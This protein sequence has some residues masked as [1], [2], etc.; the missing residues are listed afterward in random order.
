MSNTLR[1]EKA[2]AQW[3][4]SGNGGFSQ[5][6]HGDKPL[7]QRNYQRVSANPVVF[8]GKTTIFRPCGASC[9]PNSISAAMARRVRSFIESFTSFQST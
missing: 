8:P 5:L 2:M 9:S 4:S 3:K 1:Q 7:R 6:E